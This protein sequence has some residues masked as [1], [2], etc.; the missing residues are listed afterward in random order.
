MNVQAGLEQ[1]SPE[2]YAKRG[3]HI[4]ASEVAAVMGLNP[5]KPAKELW[6][7]KTGQKAKFEGNEH[8]RRGELLEPLVREI[9]EF[10]HGSGPLTTP[11][12]EWSEWPVL[13][14]SLDGLWPGGEI[15]AELKAPRIGSRLVGE[16]YKG[17]MPAYYYAQ[18]QQ[19]LLLSGALEAH[20]VVYDGFWITTL[21]VLPEPEFQ[22]ALVA[23]CRIFWDRVL[24]REWPEP[25]PDEIDVTALLKKAKRKR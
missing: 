3:S 8:T 13:S 17:T 22:E 5:F 9:Y 19:Q 20:F 12:L 21:R 10:V 16:A 1:R 14:A 23:K 15:I 7:E 25:D 24:S 6:L 2:W 4:G 11:S 18:V